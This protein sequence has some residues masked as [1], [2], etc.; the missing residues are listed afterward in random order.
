MDQTAWDALALRWGGWVQV[1]LSD[2]ADP[3]AQK[4]VMEHE[5]YKTVI[6]PIEECKTAVDAKKLIE[7]TP[8]RIR[9]ALMSP[10]FDDL[11]SAFCGLRKDNEQEL[12][13][14]ENPFQWAVE[15]GCLESIR[16]CAVLFEHDGRLSE[17]AAAVRVA[18]ALNW[19]GTVSVLLETVKDKSLVY[20]HALNSSLVWLSWSC[21]DMLL[22]VWRDK[23]FDMVQVVRE[24][25]KRAS[26]PL[27]DKTIAAG[28]PVFTTSYLLPVDCDNYNGWDHISSAK[29][30]ELTTFFTSF[31][32][33]RPDLLS[34]YTFIWI[35]LHFT[36]RSARGV[37]RD[38]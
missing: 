12:V 10:F 18:A 22:P 17:I 4:V 26:V 37:F 7:A 1:I 2:T 27:F 25:W 15:F 9:N 23:K 11:R 32:D 13:S 35:L 8:D 5:Y 31:Q 29:Y 33:T 34:T 24:I 21:L 19:T 6:Q 3:D 14:T 36:L 20:K 28:L 30:D 16:Y 38:V